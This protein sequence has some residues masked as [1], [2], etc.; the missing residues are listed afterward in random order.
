MIDLPAKQFIT[1]NGHRLAYLA[2]GDPSKPAIVFIHGWL[3]HAGV[4]SQT[5]AA[6]RD[7]H[8]C[9]AVDLLGLA[10]SDKPR[11][12]DYSITAQAARV[13]AVVDSLGVETFTLFGHSMGG[14]IAL[15][16]AAFAPERI[17]RVVDVAG[18]ASGRLHNAILLSLKRMGLAVGRPWL[19]HV[20]N[21]LALRYRP[22]ARFS[23]G[24]WF[25]K[26]NDLKWESWA[27]DRQM[28]LQPSMNISA[29]RCGEAIISTDL[30]R[31]LPQIAAPTLIVFGE[32]DAVVPV[33]EGR[34]AFQQIPISHLAILP[35]CGHFPMYECP[36][37]YLATVQ[38]FMKTEPAVIRETV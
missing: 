24:T 16:L 3:S 8:Y 35:D 37:E 15:Y 20:E 31:F 18:V 27:V 22:Y 13:L 9:V 10:E 23:W 30:T 19:W 4:W 34:L 38:N 12:G 25:Y 21:W 14:Q 6:L 17:L 28:S 1:V 32:Y 29:Y 5:I 26:M 33:D 2:V 7:T 11:D 36:E